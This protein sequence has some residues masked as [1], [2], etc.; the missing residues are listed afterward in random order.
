MKDATTDFFDGIAAR[1][2][3]PLLERA[4]GTLR[5]ELAKGAKKERWLVS[6]D[7][8][9]VAVSHRNIGADCTMRAP[10]ELFDR[11]ATGEV[12]A[13]AAVLRGEIELEGD[14]ELLVLFQRLF[15]GPGAPAAATRSGAKR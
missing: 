14:S 6:I 4:S 12:N 10:K 1:Q 11:V 13:L 9:N 2:R 15:P 5:V 7:K 3:V 8:G